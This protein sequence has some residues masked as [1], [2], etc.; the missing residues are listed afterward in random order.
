M[1]KRVAL[2]LVVCMIASFA[3]MGVGCGQQAD[4]A[5]TAKD[6]D[7][8]GAEAQDPVDDQSADAQDP[9]GDDAT[10]ADDSSAPGEGHKVGLLPFWTGC[11][12]FD[13][14][15]AGGFWYLKDKGAD[16]IVEN[17][18]WDTMQYNTIC[19]TWST[20][21][22]LEAVIA[23]PLGGQEVA[24]GLK[25]LS[26][27]GKKLAI[28]NNEAG[29]LP[30]ALFSVRYD[31]IEACAAMGTKVVELL[32]EQKGEAKGV[33]IMGLGDTKNPEHIERAAAVRSVFE[34]YPDLE[35]REFESGMAADTAAT[36]TADL[37]RTEDNVVAVVSVGMLEFVGMVNAL[38]RENMA[39]PIG[40][41]KH[42][43]CAGVD[44]A[45]EVINPGIRNGIVDFAIDQPVL[46]YNA[47]AA[48]YM[49]NYLNEGESA[50]PQAGDTI[51]AED[52]DL[53]VKV[54]S[55]GIDLM[56]PPDSWAPATVMDTVD[57]FG[58]I[59]I[60]TQYL[61]IDKSNVDD[62]LL[63]SNISG[64]ISDFGF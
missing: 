46:A 4:P 42:I 21:D 25:A 13:P 1:K 7:D 53:Q 27:A 23:A 33:V 26:E 41:E 58:H 31:G 44:T 35:L 8:Q 52:V 3:L 15:T 20:L 38:Q 22:D 16:A 57:D 19:N 34:Q 14:F 10:A 62:P 24:T 18:Q 17:A 43:V 29:M 48:Y 47:I 30:E 9:A 49:L 28:T 61:V 51:N 60:K 40:D 5:D 12:W 63:W 2:L 6:A 50:L 55:E 11:L 32:K 56:T 45:P 64:E 37:L 59:W 39:F 36:R 54:P